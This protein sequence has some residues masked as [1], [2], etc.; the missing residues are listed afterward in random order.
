MT[1]AATSGAAPRAC[2][3]ACAGSLTGDAADTRYGRAQVQP[4][5]VGRK[6]TSTA[7]VAHPARPPGDHPVGRDAVAGSGAPAGAAQRGCGGWTSAVP[8]TSLG[9]LTSSPSAPDKAVG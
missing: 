1:A 7:A 2:A 8:C 3:C 9:H 5:G 6:I 4:T